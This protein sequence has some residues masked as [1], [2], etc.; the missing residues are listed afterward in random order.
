M[1]T[2]TLRQI[3]DAGP[4]YDPRDN[5]LLPADH[6]FDAPIGFR[7]IA[8]KVSA[9]DL[10]WCFAHALPSHDA[11]KRHFSVDCAERVRYLMTDQRSLNA[12]TVARRHALGKATDDELNAA[13]DA[14]YG[15]AACAAMDAARAARDAYWAA[16]AAQQAERRWQAERLIQ[17]AEAGEWSPAG[18]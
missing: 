8:A 18:E 7:E 2:I 12:L 11:L 10:V 5:G 14:A 4:C 13:R 16:D 3:L 1:I 9:A 6:G 17:L 15:A